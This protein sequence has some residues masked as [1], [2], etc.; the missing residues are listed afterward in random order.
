MFSRFQWFF[1][2]TKAFSANFVS[3]LSSEVEWKRIWKL[4]CSMWRWK[5]GKSEALEGSGWQ[6]PSWEFRWW[7]LFVWFFLKILSS[8]LS[9]SVSH[10]GRNT[11]FRSTLH[12]DKGSLCMPTSKLH[13]AVTR[14]L[15]HIV[16]MERNKKCKLEFR[17]HFDSPASTIPPA[18]NTLNFIKFFIMEKS[19]VCSHAIYSLCR[20]LRALLF[21]ALWE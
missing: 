16:W 2:S 15:L 4:Y 11:L 8:N 14:V 20:C 17:F 18:T 6:Q 13:N 12:Q 19:F 21:G 1:K 3:L 7:L 9:L 5:L 10:L